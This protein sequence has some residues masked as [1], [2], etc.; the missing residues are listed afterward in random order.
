MQRAREVG[1]ERAR[2]TAE[3]E[4]RASEAADRSREA[5]AKCEAVPLSARL[6]DAKAGLVSDLVRRGMDRGAAERHAT[7]AAERAARCAR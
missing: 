7:A 6:M 4:R 3:A 1:E 2:K 5:R